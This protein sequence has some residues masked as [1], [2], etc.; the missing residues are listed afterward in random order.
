MKLRRLC[1]KSCPLAVTSTAASTGGVTDNVAHLPN[2]TEAYHDFVDAM[3]E[4]V[5]RLEEEVEEAQRL[6]DE[7]GT[8]AARQALKKLD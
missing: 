6:K 2:T 1:E 8:K 7:H 5:E 3:A 4:I